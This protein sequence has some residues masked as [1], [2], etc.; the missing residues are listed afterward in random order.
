VR[1]DTA[2]AIQPDPAPWVGGGRILLI[3]ASTGGVEALHT[4]LSAFPHD[5]PPTIIVQHMRPAFVESFVDGLDRRC[6]ADVVL[7]EDRQVVRP[8]R[9]YVAPAG[10]LHLVLSAHPAVTLRLREAPPAHGHR[11]AVDPLFLSAARLQ[12]APVA[13]LLTGMGRDG[14]EGLLRIREAGGHTIAQDEASAVVY[15]MPRAARDIGA[16][17]QILPLHAI[18]AALF[19]AAAQPPKHRRSGPR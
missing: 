18:A 8:G 14:A 11:P 19:Q 1:P 13:V 10:D 12:P 3:G 17:D 9:V 7:A 2:K 15:G 5:C 4:L 16:A 6:A